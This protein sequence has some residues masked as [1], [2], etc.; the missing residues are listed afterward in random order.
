MYTPPH[1]PPALHSDE[2]RVKSKRIQLMRD[3]RKNI[4]LLGML[5][6]VLIWYAIFSYGPLYGIQLAFKDFR[7][8]EGIGG[9]PWVGLKHFAYMF[10]A[11][12][13]FPVILKNTFIISFLHI[14]FGFPAPILLALLFNELRSRLFTRTAQTITYLPYFFSWVIVTSL[15]ITV[16]SPSS[17]V[18]NMVV[19]W[20]GFEPIYFL[21]DPQYFRSVLVV[22]AI[23]KDAGYGAIIYL[24]ALA[25]ID[26]VMYEAAKVDGVG[27]WRQLWSI[28]LP[29]IMPV[30]AIMFLFRL[31]GI[32]DAGFDQ[33][34]NMY[35][36]SVYS[37]SDIIDTYVY[38]VGLGQMQYSFS[39]AVGL[40]KNVVAL[41]L[42][43]AANYVV[44]KSG[45]EGLF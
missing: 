40:F 36:P 7:I 26:P 30:I 23:W 25:S 5:A 15:A 35:N 37:V 1:S 41:V 10:N 2:Q 44:K 42:V 20:F 21:A 38:R 22:S 3:Y 39:T 24:A 34:L 9:S 14:L 16:L 29:G 6:P 28:T 27:K 11:S 18:V 45:Q 17:G 8:M 32:L 13:Q 12:P 33:I 43:V 4:Y 19:Q 31:M